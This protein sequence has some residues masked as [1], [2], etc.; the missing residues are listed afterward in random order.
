MKRIDTVCYAGLNYILTNIFKLINKVLNADFRLK[1]FTHIS[2]TSDNLSILIN[3]EN[4]KP[5]NRLN[6][7]LF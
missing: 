5:C 2:V 1:S 6:I 4:I 3:N 7:L